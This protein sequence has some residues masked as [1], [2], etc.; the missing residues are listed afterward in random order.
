M[1]FWITRTSDSR[2]MPQPQPHPDAQPGERRVMAGRGADSYD[3]TPKAAW[4]MDFTTLDDLMAF[5]R[6]LGSGFRGAVIFHDAE[7]GDELEIY[8]DYRE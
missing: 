8:D 7:T 1:R 2:A 4:W 6:S 3:L 5:I